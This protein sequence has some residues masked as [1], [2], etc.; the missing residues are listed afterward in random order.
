M[1]AVLTALSVAHAIEADT[2]A[3]PG[4]VASSGIV[5]AAPAARQANHVAVIT[6]DGPIDHVTVYSVKR[7]MSAAQSAGAD[8]IVFEINTPG[9][10]AYAALEIC[11]L[12]KNSPIPNTVAWINTDAYSAGVFIALACREIVVA[13]YATMGDAAPIKIVPGMGLQTMGET[14]RQKMLSPFISE[15]VDSARRHGYDEMLVQAFVTLGVELW[16]VENTETSERMFVTAEEYRL[17][18]PGEPPRSSPRMVAARTEERRAPPPANAE[19]GAAPPRESPSDYIPAGPSLHGA[20]LAE[21]VGA[22]LDAPSARPMLTRADRGKYRLIEYATDG[23]TL[24]VLKSEDMKRYGFASGV[25]RNDEELKTF[26]G[27]TQL[28]RMHRSWSEALVVLLTNMYV[29]GALIVVFL[30]GMFIEM[31]APG[32]GVPGVVAGLCLVGLLAPPLLIGAS[33]WWTVAAVFAGLALILVEIFVLPGLTFFGVGG[34]L[35]LLTGLIGTFIGNDPSRFGQELT[36]GVAIV[37]MAFFVA[38]VGMYFVSRFYGTLPVFN[39]LV[40]SDRPP[41]DESENGAPAPTPTEFVARVKVGD[42]GVAITPLRPSGTAQFDDALVDVVSDTGFIDQGARVRV[43][44]VTRYRV[45]VEL[46]ANGTEA[47]S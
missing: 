8:A 42:A 28:T 39:R 7:R 26:F 24:L 33:G 30:L 22:L 34:V 46:A 32:V 9:G 14:E 12:I 44:D 25:V 37:L 2:P 23:R 43:I 13:E 40:L 18:F 1:L 15:L 20:E 27:A 3:E 45:A 19:P 10:A 17:L 11:T 47:I 31:A 35:L 38:G 6:I 5:R 21:E 29:R 4:A 41:E 16:L 36:Y